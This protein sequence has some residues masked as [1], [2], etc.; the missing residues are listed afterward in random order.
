MSL[1]QKYRPLSF[2]SV[3]G[4]E[5]E[6]EALKKNLE[7]PV[8]NHFILLHG[9]YGTGKTTLAR[10]IKNA[11]G[12]TEHSTT[13]LN[14]ADQNG[15]ET[16]RG[17][18]R[19]MNQV[20]IDHGATV[21][22]ID[23]AHQIT[24]PAQEAFLKLTEDIPPHVWFIFATTEPTKINKGLLSR[25]MI[26]KTKLIEKPNML[27]L[28][29]RISKREGI[30][31][32]SLGVAGAIVEKAQGSARTAINLLETVSGH[33]NKG[34]ALQAVGKYVENE[35]VIDLCQGLLKSFE[36]SKISVMLKV[37]K[38]DNDVET[39]RRI[40]CGYMQAVVLNSGKGRAAQILSKF[41]YPMYDTGW[42]EIILVCFELSQR[43][44]S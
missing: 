37:L 14:T 11:V 3:V 40:V 25:A 13:E 23:E 15:I 20:S 24:K 29:K 10:L 32:K 26:I 42:H 12:G 22:I 9:P 18:A 44:K 28:L 7:K 27:L 4:L 33:D 1:Y 31:L 5:K 35:S 2:D 16:V 6:I 38:V 30:D 34:D 21:Y 8:C 19:E 36:W 43:R 17:V 41:M 39:I